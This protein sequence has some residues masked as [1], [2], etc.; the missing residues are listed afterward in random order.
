MALQKP[1]IILG[2]AR[3]GTTLLGRLL[4]H[5]PDVAYW[6]EPNHIWRHRHAYRRTDVLDREDATPAV[7]RHIRKQFEIFLRKSGRSRFAEKTPTNCLRVPFIRE[8]FPDALFI[9]L[10][11]DGRAVA[12]S[13]RVQWTYGEVITERKLRAAASNTSFHAR[14]S[15]ASRLEHLRDGAFAAVKFIT[16]TRKLSGGVWAFIEAP[17]SARGAF[18]T[19]GRK[20]FRNHLFIWGP[21][22]PGLVE[23]ARTRGVLEACAYQWA[24]CVRAVQENTRDLPADQLLELRYEDLLQHPAEML[25][26]ICDF[27]GLRPSNE[28]MAACAGVR[29]GRPDSWQENVTDAERQMLE[30]VLAPV[31]RDLGYATVNAGVHAE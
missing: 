13:A 28:V 20:L 19:L 24:T 7:A 15:V 5:H 30:T 12:V 9:N 4:A 3:S 21:R 27:T 31:L 6:I 25:Q 1:I 17:A 14:R 18:A 29:E 22:S 11:R 8:V 10:V 16:E 23:V 2:A 26:R